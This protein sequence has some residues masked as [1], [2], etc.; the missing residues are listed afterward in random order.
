MLAILFYIGIIWI[1]T[2]DPVLLGEKK[3]R[4]DPPP[5]KKTNPVSVPDMAPLL[6]VPISAY[7]TLTIIEKQSTLMPAGIRQ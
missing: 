6:K 1:L 4:L 2:L 7:E 3:R 5:Q